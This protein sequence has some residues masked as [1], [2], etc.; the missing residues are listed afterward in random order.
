MCL[1]KK[2][3]FQIEKKHKNY[4][5][6]SMKQFSTEPTFFISEPRKKIIKE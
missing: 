1:F 2:N 4:V 5:I 3:T 6:S